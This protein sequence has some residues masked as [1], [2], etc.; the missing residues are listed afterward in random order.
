MPPALGVVVRYIW[1]KSNH[2]GSSHGTGHDT[3]DKEV[4]EPRGVSTRSAGPEW[5]TGR[6]AALLAQVSDKEVCHP[7]VWL[8]KRGGVL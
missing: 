4:C 6:S 1:Y 3:G 8:Q 5:V 7:G 2:P